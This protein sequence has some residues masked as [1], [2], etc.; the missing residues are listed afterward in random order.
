MFHENRQLGRAPVN[1]WPRG[2]AVV[3]ACQLIHDVGGV[4]VQE[5]SPETSLCR[6]QQKFFSSLFF[7]D[8][9][10]FSFGET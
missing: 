9:F 10:F 3:L 4:S 7:L 1:A 8:F 2:R 6:K 5:L